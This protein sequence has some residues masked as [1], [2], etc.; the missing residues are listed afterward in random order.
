MGRRN[1][2]IQC[3]LCLFPRDSHDHVHLLVP[4]PRALASVVLHGSV[5]RATLVN[6]SCEPLAFLDGHNTDRFTPQAN[7][8]ARRNADKVGTHTS[9]V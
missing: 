3:E 8:L 4:F 6:G 2:T 1:L 5:A 7:H 9:R